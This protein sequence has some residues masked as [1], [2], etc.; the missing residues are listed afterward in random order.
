MPHPPTMITVMALEWVTDIDP[1]GGATHHMPLHFS[2][3][4]KNEI[5]ILGWEAT[6]DQNTAA[7]LVLEA[8]YTIKHMVFV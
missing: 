5:K 4:S 6:C 8:P 7:I 3:E 2:S 1:I